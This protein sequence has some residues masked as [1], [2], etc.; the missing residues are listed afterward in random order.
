MTAAAK[1]LVA[2]AC[3]TPAA[4]VHRDRALGGGGAHVSAYEAAL[5]NLGAKAAAL[6][7]GARR[8]LGLEHAKQLPSWFPD[9][10]QRL[11]SREADFLSAED[12]TAGG[13][14]KRFAEEALPDLFAGAPGMMSEVQTLPHFASQFGEIPEDV[15]RVESTESFTE[16][17]TNGRTERTTRRCAGG[18]CVTETVTVEDEQPSEETETFDESEEMSFNEDGA[19][20]EDDG[21]FTEEENRVFN[22]EEDEEEEEEAKETAEPQAFVVEVT[23]EQSSAL[24]DAAGSAFR[25]VART[26]G[27]GLAT[28]FKS[29]DKDAQQ[30]LQ[31]QPKEQVQASIGT[32]IGK[33]LGHF[34]DNVFQGK[35]GQEDKEDPWLGSESMSVVTRQDDSGKMVQQTRTC[36]NGSCELK[37]REVLKVKDEEGDQEQEEDV[38]DMM[39]LAPG[40]E[41]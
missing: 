32:T 21:V 4:G 39:P 28:L 33:T 15:H 27:R 19:D 31:E 23:P 37:E 29:H 36:K 20:E 9:E 26:L 35:G 8:E 18:R 2:A 12:L 17:S 40:S 5:S 38:F 22:G 34:L 41:P 16:S 24:A 7:K 14:L 13:M 10:A 3:L 1:L 25:G 11:V 6:V 30:V